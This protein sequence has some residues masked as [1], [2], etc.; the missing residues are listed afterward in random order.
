MD[1]VYDL[2]FN[3]NIS[4]YIYLHLDIYLTIS[5]IKYLYINTISIY[6]NALCVAY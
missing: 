5:N 3:V 1:N 4:M 6:K 2:I